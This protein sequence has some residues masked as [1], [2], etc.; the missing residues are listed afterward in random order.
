MEYSKWNIV[1]LHIHSAFSNKVKKNDYKGP[2][3]SAIQLLEKLEEYI[4][5][6]SMIFSITD[7]NSIDVDLYTD[8]F[9]EIKTER[10]RDK[11]ACIIGVEI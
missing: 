10:F 7:H 9:K 5:N 2:K 8:I 6:E 1:D 4:A 11:F 3:Y